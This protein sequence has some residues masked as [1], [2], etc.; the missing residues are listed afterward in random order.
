LKFVNG[1]GIMQV[2][3]RVG[4]RRQGK[5]DNDWRLDRYCA[6]D[7]HGALLALKVEGLR[8]EQA[9]RGLRPVRS[10]VGSYG[11][12]GNSILF[13]LHTVSGSGGVRWQKAGGVSAIPSL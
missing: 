2:H 11:F 10:T 9:D 3:D 12:G 8:F 1:G 4:A 5:N 7:V 6:A 13:C